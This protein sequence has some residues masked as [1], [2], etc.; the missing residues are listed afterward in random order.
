MRWYAAIA[1]QLD[2]ESLSGMLPLL[3]HPVA[4][5]AEDESGKVHGAVKE[6]AGEA[7]QMLQ[8]RASPPEFVAAYQQVKEAQRSARRE[9]KRPQR[10]V[11][12]SLAA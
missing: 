10:V 11:L 4:R 9:R 6:L 1:N 5:A 2:A 7:L 8:K 3:L 12:G